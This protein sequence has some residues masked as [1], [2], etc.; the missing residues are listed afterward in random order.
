M[1]QNHDGLIKNCCGHGG[2]GGHAAMLAT[3]ER[4]AEDDFTQAAMG[5]RRALAAHAHAG[6][7]LLALIGAALLFGLV[8]SAHRRAR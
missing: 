2:H 6:A 3:D 1:H 5:E 8:K 4:Y 7:A